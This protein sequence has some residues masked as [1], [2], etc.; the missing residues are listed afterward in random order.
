MRYCK[1]YINKL[2]W[3]NWFAWYPVPTPHDG[4]ICWVWFETIQRVYKYNE[5]CPRHDYSIVS[6]TKACT[7]NAEFKSGE[8]GWKYRLKD[9]HWGV[10]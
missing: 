5:K 1:K 4:K 6:D 7:C 10:I 9:L 2:R 8:Y 3:H